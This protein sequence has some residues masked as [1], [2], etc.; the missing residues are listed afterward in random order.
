M[1]KP[2]FSTVACPEWTI[3]RVAMAAGR[4]G[5]LGVEFRTFDVSSRRF[6]CDPALTDPAKVRRMLADH[7]VQACCVSTDASFDNMV[8]PPV[9]GHIWTDD[10]VQVRKARRAIDIA[11]EIEAPFV[12]VFGFRQS[13]IDSRVNC[14]GRIAQRLGKVV[15][16]AVKSGVRVLLENGGTFATSTDALEILAQ[17]ETRSDNQ[18]LRVGYN[19]CAAAI[20][21]EDP[22]EG[23]LKLQAAGGGGGG[24]NGGVGGGGG[25]GGGGGK[26][27]L[28]KIKDVRDGRPVALGTGAWG[29]PLQA[30]VAE[31]ARA[32]S[33]SSGGS[34]GWGDIWCVFEWDRAWLPDIGEPEFALDHAARTIYQWMN[35][36]T[37]TQTRQPIAAG[38]YEGRL[39]G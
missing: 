23:F 16:H 20:A 29:G 15:D 11:A 17:F 4:M 27:P 36:A 1:L 13:A 33:S 7:G 31:A 37:P 5:Y 32:S 35:Q 10:E 38:A 39:Q 18:L 30:L 8:I 12:R 34:A 14:V 26:A 25:G 2:A 28:I 6:A 21:G 19:A 22:L 24:G 3:D 9:V